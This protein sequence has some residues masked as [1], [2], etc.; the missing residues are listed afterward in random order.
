MFRLAARGIGA[1]PKLDAVALEGADGEAA[2]IGTRDIF[3]EGHDGLAEAAIYAFEKL[4]PGNKLNG[5]AV[6]HTPITTIVLQDNQIG[7]L[8]QYRNMIIEFA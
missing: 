6:V 5:P 4:R 3:V 8:D 7:R 2:R 1:R